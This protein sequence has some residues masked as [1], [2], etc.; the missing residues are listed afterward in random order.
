MPDSNRSRTLIAATGAALLLTIASALGI[1]LYQ[2][3]DSEIAEW[4]DQLDG[5]A[6]LLAEQTA[7]EMS[8]ADLM[9]DGML[10]RIRLLGV[11]DGATLRA[12][13]GD[14]AEF[15]RLLDRK[16]V[17]PQIDVATIVAA[18][19]QVV[20]FTRSHPAPAISLADR[21]YFQA[22]RA[23]PELGLYVSKPVR[24]KGN[25]A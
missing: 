11:E 2:A 16:R 19:G 23:S 17:L 21:D 14:E 18:D 20:N 24:N 3:R 15:Q 7:H 10:E 13:L 8:A 12:R 1:A 9:L 6:L 22:H 25:G 5:T 4:R